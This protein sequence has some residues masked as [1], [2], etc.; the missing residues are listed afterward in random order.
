MGLTVR[1]CNDRGNGFKLKER[2]CSLEAGRKVLAQKAARHWHR[3]HREAAYAPSLE[4]F[5]AS[6]GGPFRKPACSR[7]VGTR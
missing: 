3:L 1:E 6:W 2:R 5:K 4:V 7:K